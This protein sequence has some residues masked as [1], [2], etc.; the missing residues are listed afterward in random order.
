MDSQLAG[1]LHSF[2][3]HL[4]RIGAAALVQ[5]SFWKVPV[6]NASD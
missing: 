3:E 4:P 1:I 5:G 6:Q 2:V